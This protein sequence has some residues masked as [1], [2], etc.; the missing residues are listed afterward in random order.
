MAALPIEA[1]IMSGAAVGSK[2]YLFGGK[3][4]NGALDAIHVFDAETNTVTTL[5]T[6]MSTKTY[7]MAVAA[8]GEKVYLFGGQSSSANSGYLGTIHVFDSKTETLTK[9][10]AT[11][12]AT[13][14]MAAVAIG[15]NIYLFGGKTS[16]TWSPY[17][18]VFNTESNT[19][20][21]ISTNLQIEAGGM[22]AAAVGT[23]VYLFGGKNTSGHQKTIQVFDAETHTT[24]TLSTT[25]PTG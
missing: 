22:A 19:I 16:T 20:Y 8:V 5:S 25:I 15:N 4:S 14:D 21:S 10:S 3:S 11:F 7:G 23:K 17:I 18:R 9:L 2:V 6:I 13:S 1:G 24:T 12:A